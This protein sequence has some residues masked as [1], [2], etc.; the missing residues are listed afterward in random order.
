MSGQPQVLKACASERAR[1][2]ARVHCPSP[3]AVLPC[4]A[5]VVVVG[6]I[7]PEPEHAARTVG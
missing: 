6:F 5:Y 7:S 3:G 4:G 2:R 1:A